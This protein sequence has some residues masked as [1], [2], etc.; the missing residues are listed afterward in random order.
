MPATILGS[1]QTVKKVFPPIRHNVAGN[2][3]IKH[4]I[5]DWDYKRKVQISKQGVQAKGVEAEM[6]LGITR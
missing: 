6:R 2:I 3:E 5:M 1:G 4:I